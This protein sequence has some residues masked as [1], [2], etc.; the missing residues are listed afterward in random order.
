MELLEGLVGRRSIRKF[1]AEKL[2][3]ALAEQII[4]RA[5]FAPSWSNVKATR[6]FLIESDALIKKISSF[7]TP[8][9]R[10]I[11]EKAPNLFVLTAVKGRS[12][13]GTDH[14]SHTPDEWLM[15]D[16]GIAAQTLCLA[17]HGL[18]VGTV[19]TGGYDI[20][21]LALALPLPA[22]E[23]VVLVIAAGFP[24]EAPTA[25]KRKEVGEILRVIK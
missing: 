25:P 11:L 9:N 12:G 20:D 4:D 24:D 21:A 6:Y 23:R 1:K 19:I 13:S 7:C 17:A 3:V 18:G 5:R 22:D 15:L 2:P 14:P 16:T 10:A 8:W